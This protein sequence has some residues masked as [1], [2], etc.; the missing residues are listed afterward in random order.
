MEPQPALVRAD[1]IV[2]LHAVTDIHMHRTP[3]VH[4]RHFECENTVRFHD[5]FGDAVR[6][7]FRMTVVNLLDRKQHFV[8]RLQVLALAG[9]THCEFVH[10]F[11][12]LHSA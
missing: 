9:V 11:L 7:E 8:Y 1:R 2:E 12:D 10:Q 4:P 5:P 3:V 6:L